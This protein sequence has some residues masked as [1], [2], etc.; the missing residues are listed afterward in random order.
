MR[1]ISMKHKRNGGAGHA[2][3]HGSFVLAA[4]VIF[5]ALFGGVQGAAADDISVSG[6]PGSLIIGSATAGSD[7]VPVSDATTTY[8][9]DITTGTMK[10]TGALDSSM[11]ANTS[12]TVQLGAPVGATSLGKV[13]LSA[14]SSDLVTGIAN[15]TSEAGLV[16]SYEFSASVLAGVVSATAK[17]VTL[18]ISD[19]L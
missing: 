14:A 12:L 8:S 2:C 9:I 19:N 1:S 15:G 18:T 4:V 10:I 6:N 16:I 17:T 11:P 5:L 7:L 3:G 13:T